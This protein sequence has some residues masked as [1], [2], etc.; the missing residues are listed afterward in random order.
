M[1]NP[2]E[3]DARKVSMFLSERFFSKECM[4]PLV[5]HLL[6]FKIVALECIVKHGFMNTR[7]NILQTSSFSEGRVLSVSLNVTR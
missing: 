1:R 6:N 2:R 3:D 7:S 5:N 4:E